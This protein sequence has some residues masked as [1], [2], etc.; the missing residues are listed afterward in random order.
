LGVQKVRFRRRFLGVKNRKCSRQR[1]LRN[2][3][4]HP[5]PPTTHHPPRP[6]PLKQALNAVG[7]AVPCVAYD[8]W[9]VHAPDSRTFACVAD[10]A[11]Y[12]AMIL[13]QGGPA[14]AAQWAALEARMAPLQRGAALLP[15]A[16]LRAD[17]GVALTA[18]RV[19]PALLATAL[20][21]GALTAPFSRLL[22][23]VVTD[24][25]LRAMMDLECFVLSGMLAKDTITAEMVR[26]SG[27]FPLYQH[28]FLFYLSLRR[29]A[30]FRSRQS[31]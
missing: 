16:A 24:P 13:E 5:T 14:A 6:N 20:Q 31:C 9:T 17:L 22:D 19:G 11:K 29:T 21:A 7:E 25:W 27:R 4:H 8:Q 26:A 10:G 28:C 3:K 1:P 30:P 2:H 23:G 12:R 18:A 15:A